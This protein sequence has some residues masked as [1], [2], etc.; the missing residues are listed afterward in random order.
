M[1]LRELLD[2]LRS[3]DENSRLE[4]K[5]GSQVGDS[6]LQ[7]ICAFANE[8]GLGGGTIL[9][10]VERT[11]EGMLF[12]DY[13]VC[14]VPDP[15][16]VQADLVTQCRNVFSTP[17][18]VTVT[19][20]QADGGAVLIVDV[21][22]A[23][24]ASKPVH[25]ARKPLPGGAFRRL[26]SADVKCTED[27]I[28]LLFQQ[29]R[30]TPFDATLVEGATMEDVEPDAIALYRTTRQATNPAAEELRMG[31]LDLLRALRCVEN[32]P[33]GPILTLAGLLL[34]G[35]AAAQRRLLPMIRLDYV[36]VPGRDW[37]PEN[38]ERF[39][40]TLD[41][42]GPLVT[43]LGRAQAA[44]LDDLPRAFH[45]PEGKMQREDKPRL[46]TRVIREAVVN[47]L[48]H[49]SYRS[50][51]PTQ[52]IRFA[53]R[54]E[55]RNP[56]YSLKAP[57][58]LG[59]PG[60]EPRNPT[61]AAVLHELNFAETKGTGIRIMQTEMR[62][63]GLTPAGFESDREADAFTATFLFHH[64]LEEEDVAWLAR[65][66]SL[67]LTDEMLKA[68]V[69]V[70]ERGRINNVIY[71]DIAQCHATDATRDLRR[72]CELGLLL[73]EGNTTGRIY[74]PGPG[75]MAG[76]AVGPAVPA[77]DGSM[78]DKAATMHGKA[79]T[80]QDN[81]L[82]PVPEELRTLLDLLGRRTDP[83]ILHAVV[84]KLC[85]WQPLSVGQLADLLGRTETYTRTV[86]GAMVKEGRL[87]RTR[88]D[89]PRHP[90]QAYRTARQPPA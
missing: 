79:V 14:G 46:P 33:G 1:R 37:V 26:G 35:R 36:R 49:R 31:D 10:G 55:I 51:Q 63:A 78:H 25:F 42:R 59:E 57:E 83:G 22:E 9:L 38:G 90:D 17:L 6:I 54:L 53:N 15:D 11:D 67:G 4:V 87:E 62:R 27:D 3:L 76:G 43:L 40:S 18:S 50:Q 89:V 60:S 20:E 48:M 5:R 41:M 69:V 64:F 88:A 82:P 75:M 7:T 71:R 12:P 52:V 29:R 77:D 16:K 32:G 19:A 39:T 74:R 70:R 73:A 65:F 58:R 44:I 68:L 30:T 21:P 66:R 8:P 13:S 80:M 85:A 72:L 61:I 23:S 28:A 86:I 24:P 2:Q 81:G 45:L 56:G 34:F 47:A 84:E